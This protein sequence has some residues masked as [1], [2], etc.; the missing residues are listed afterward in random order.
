MGYQS[1]T[2]SPS[3][4]YTTE[5]YVIYKEYGGVVPYI[6]SDFVPRTVDQIYSY[7]AAPHIVFVLV[8][9]WGYNDVGFRSTYLSWTTPTFD[10]LAS[11]GVTLENYYTNQLCSPSRASLMTGRYALRTGIFENTGELSYNETTLAEEMKSAG[12]MTYLVGK[13]HLG[14]STL[15]HTPTYRGFDY[16]Y[17][18]LSGEINYWSKASQYEDYMDLME[19]STI[20]SNGDETSDKYHTAYLFADKAQAIIEKHAT[21]YPDKPMFFYYALQLI[22]SYWSAPSTYQDRCEYPTTSDN[23]TNFELWNYC[24]LNVMLDEVISNLTCVLKETGLSDNTILII[25]GDNGG[26]SDIEGNSYPFLGHK[27]TF[28]RGGISNT[29]IINSPLLPDA[30]RGLKYYGQVHITDWLPTLMGLATDGA[31]TGSLNEAAI[32]GV[33]VWDAI[34]T[35]SESPKHEIVFTNDGTACAMQYDNVTYLN[36]VPSTASYTPEFSF[37]S[38][39]DSDLSRDGLQNRSINL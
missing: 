2:E 38:D 18:Y 36:G 30:A 10:N 28:F 32:D 8:D 24:A 39:Q 25:S 29:A 31:W 16:F 22:H 13:W 6:T 19:N 11:E 7:D 35:N 12:Y 23:D 5:K 21:N 14:L 34:V 1:E 26:N 3:S 20:V 17:G 9:D 27:D 37:T 15:Q 33:D 4:A